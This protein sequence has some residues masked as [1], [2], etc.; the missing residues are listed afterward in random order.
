M[1]TFENL[2]RISEINSTLNEP[3]KMIHI[4]LDT[5]FSSKMI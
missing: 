4:L 3:F 2:Y 1:H 5:S